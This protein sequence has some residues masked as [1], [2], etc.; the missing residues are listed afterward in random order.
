MTKIGS[1]KDQAKGIDG[2]I[3]VRPVLVTSP[4]A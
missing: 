2:N 4:N 3:F 1:H